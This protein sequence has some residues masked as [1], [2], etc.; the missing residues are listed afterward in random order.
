MVPYYFL[1]LYPMVIT[2]LQN[3]RR[4]R[5]G[6]D[7]RPDESKEALTAFFIVFLGLLMCRGVSCGVDLANYQ[8]YFTKFQS[9]RWR[10]IWSYDLDKGYILLNWIIG[11][12]TTN[13]Q[14]FVAITAVLSV[15]PLFLFYKK[16]AENP[17]LTMLLFTGV[18]PFSMYFSGLRQILAMAFIYP[19]WYCA[20]EKK[21]I[22]FLLLTFL[23]MTLHSSA[24]V[25]LLIYPLYHMRITQRWLFFVVPFIVGVYI[26]KEPIL[27][28]L[29][30]VFWESRTSLSDTGA[31]TVLLMLIMFAVYAYVIPDERKLDTDTVA[32]RNMLLLMVTIQCMAP[33]HETVMRVN[34]YFLPL[35]PLLIPRIAGRSKRNYY[36]VSNLSVLVLSLFFV[37]YFFW[38]AH[39]GADMLQVY[40]YVP[41]WGE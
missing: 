32:M 27:L 28:L 4:L 2:L 7:S 30:R 37:F 15:W 31:T 21:L 22:R 29:I 14:I 41:F 20:R 33:I 12:V 1:I 17:I 16:E 11:R 38:N 23:A 9:F 35:L 3:R 25:L 24:F 39:T 36:E 18:A 40:P 19:V 6:G 26:F 10:D 34:Y 5:I 8:Y 13:F